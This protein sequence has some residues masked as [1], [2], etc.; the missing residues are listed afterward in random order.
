M[1]LVF[2]DTE[3]TGFRAPR[4]IEIAYAV[5]SGPISV[6]RCRAP[7][8]IEEQAV[9]VHGIT[10][11]ALADLPLFTGCPQYPQTKEILE[12]GVI[13][14]HNGRFDV[15][16][17]ER[18]GIIIQSFIDTKRIAR[19]LY[20]SLKSHRLQDLCDI[21]YLEREGSAHSAAGDVFVLRKLYEKMRDDMVDNGSQPED[22]PDQMLIASR[23]A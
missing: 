21:L 2:L 4:V 6:Y 11:A 20:P 19:M 8:P 3:T 16:V 12:N 7:I 13:V 23:G 1:N 10:E 18:D 22:V 14:A 17:L 9:E 15:D 5:D